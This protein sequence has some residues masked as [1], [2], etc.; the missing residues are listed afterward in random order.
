MNDERV[1]IAFEILQY[2]IDNP[3]AQDTLEGIVTWWLLVRDIKQQTLSVK[4]ALALLVE[5]HLVIAQ[6]GRDSRIYYKI[7]RRQRKRIISLL[8]QKA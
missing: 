3:E 6:K 2:L 7:N 4:E 8:K 5:D 1:Q